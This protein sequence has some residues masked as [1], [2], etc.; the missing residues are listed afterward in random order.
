MSTIRLCAE[1]GTPVPEDAPEGACPAC[2]LRGALAL[3]NEG[4][5]TVVAEK[6]GDCIGPYKLAEML[7]E[8]GC[9]MV[10]L[11][12]QAEPIRREVALKVIKLGM[13]TKQVIARFENERQALA[14]MDHPNI[15]RVFEAGATET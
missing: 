6:T 15:A 3:S 8:G 1:C 12:V 5:K 11:A 14:V 13:D 4:S 7:G 9:G 2:V 10:Y